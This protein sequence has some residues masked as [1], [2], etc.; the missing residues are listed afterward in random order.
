[1]CR[2]GQSFGFQDHPNVEIVAVTDLFPDRCAEMAKACRCKKTYPSCEE[3][4]KDDTIE[5]VFIATDAPSHARLAIMALGLGKHVCVAVPAT[6]GSLEDGEKL[7][8]TYK[9]AAGPKKAAAEK[10]AAAKK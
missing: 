8:E 5:A 7:F 3:M 1:M 10:K 9:K 6:F 4:L 2:F